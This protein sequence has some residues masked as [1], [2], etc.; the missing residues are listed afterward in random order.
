M[1]KGLDDYW[2]QNRDW[3]HFEGFTQVINDNAPQKAKESYKKYLE[4]IE[5]LT[6]GK[7]VL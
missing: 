3:W 7:R 6:K 2:E 1:T 4:Q 5:K